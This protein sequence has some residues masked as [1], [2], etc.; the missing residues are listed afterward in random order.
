MAG[1]SLSKGVRSLEPATSGQCTLAH[2][3][4]PAQTAR[5][6]AG[7]APASAGFALASGWSWSAAGPGRD[8]RPAAQRVRYQPDSWG[9]AI[10]I[11]RP[12]RRTRPPPPLPQRCR[13]VATGKGVASSRLL[14]G[15]GP[16][17][18]PLLWL[19][20][21]SMLGVQHRRDLQPLPSSG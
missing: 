14:F 7:R 5:R 4:Q 10:A 16:A 2:H 3:A 11:A 1:S 13:C 6:C 21:T 18:V 15:R 20:D 12:L 19:V 9:R 8:P 17:D